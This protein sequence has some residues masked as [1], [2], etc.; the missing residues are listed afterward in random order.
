MQCEAGSIRLLLIRDCGGADWVPRTGERGRCQHEETDSTHPPLRTAPKKRPAQ[1]DPPPTASDFGGSGSFPIVGIGASAGGLEAL[2]RFF[3]NVP[4]GTRMAFVVVQHLDPTHEGIL[5]ELLQRCTS[6]TVQQVKDR[7]RVQPEHVYVIPPNKDL[8]LRRGILRLLVPAAPRGLRLPIDSFFRSLAADQ[9]E[10]SLGIILSGMGS[11]GTLGLTA[12]KERSGWSLVQ[13]PSTAKFDGMP[14]SAI[15]ARLADV[16]ASPEELPAKLAFLAR[17][18][19][20]D[21]ANIDSSG[22]VS[23]SEMARIIQLLRSETGHDFSLYRKSTLYRRIERRMGIHRFSRIGDYAQFLGANPQETQ[24]LFKELLIGITSFF[25]DPEV[26]ETLRDEILPPLLAERPEGAVLR[27]WIPGCSTGEE[28]YS[29]GMVF[30][31]AVRLAR[32]ARHR[33][34]R[35][36]A[37]D[38]DRDAI[39]EARSGLYRTN[40]GADVSEERL[41]RFFLQEEHGYR[42][43]RELREMMIFAQQDVTLDPPFTRI[44]LL[45]CRNLLIYLEAELQQRLLGLFHYSLNPG[46]V[47]VLGSAETVGTSSELFL[48]VANKA[49]IYLRLGPPARAEGV[50]FAAG[51]RPAR[52]A[53][54]P[55]PARPDALPPDLNLQAL[56][57]QQILRN[58]TPAAVLVNGTGDILYVRGKT[59]KY[60]E[61]AAGKANWNLFAMAR[62][63]L[64]HP[65]NEAFQ[66]ARRKKVRVLAEDLSVRSSGRVQLVDVTVVPL[67]EPEALRGKVLFLFADAP[68]AADSSAKGKRA[69]AKPPGDRQTALARELERA[70]EE[71]R[72]SQEEMQ[73]SQDELS[74]AN[75]ELQST[76]EELQ[77]MNEELTTSKEEMQSMNEELQTINQELQAKVDELSRTSSDMHNLL[78]STDIATLF[79]DGSLH[80]RSFTD[81]IVGIFKLIP[82]DVGRPITDIVNELEYAELQADAD[83]VLSSL[84]FV[85]KQVS[86]RNG[87]WFLV[88]IMPYQTSEHRIDGLV[89]TLADI[90][91]SKRVE[92][93]L[94]A[95]E[96][97][98]RALLEERQ[99]M[100]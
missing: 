53:A 69:R 96:A 35:I 77:S 29:L 31:E 6:M 1:F 3:R 33:A 44:D 55:E 38:L 18:Q 87:R 73:A 11:D 83:A 70:D 85:E 46:G 57:D 97:K 7:M 61:P 89:I 50:E 92:A 81:R 37:S 17:H 40:I 93:E 22:R 4:S 19:V 59:G 78:N 74:S 12:I 20:R 27:A 94:R 45:S 49:R 34:L 65:L 15:D 91:A 79:L 84:K 90:S 2:E 67:L 88:R 13:A 10:R 32:P 42:V 80:V 39:D 30:E 56:A 60:L 58:H 86:A 14:R 36:F 99:R 64:G 26:W 98:L 63:G 71:L 54:G 72:T 68:A 76:N 47:L 100:E 75:E 23:G 5:A 9:E 25:R 52:R 51:R 66:R 82:G 43:R 21:L 95:T 28:A 48:P 41:G 24:L 62:N 16:I 8:A